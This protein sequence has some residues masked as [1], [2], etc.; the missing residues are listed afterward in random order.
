[1]GGAGND[2]L[3]G[4]YA[5]L[6]E[7]ALDDDSIY[8]GDGDDVLEGG[9]GNDYLDGG[10][11]TDTLYGGNGNDTLVG[12]AGDI[13]VGGEGDDIYIVDFSDLAVTSL[14]TKSFKASVANTTQYT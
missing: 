4:S 8:G 12:S 10:S 5:S 3:V 7:G 1:I 11:G 9:N 14:S 6:R 13:A 2:T